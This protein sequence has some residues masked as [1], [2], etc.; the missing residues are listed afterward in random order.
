MVIARRGSCGPGFVRD[1]RESV[2]VSGSGRGLLAR[3]APWLRGRASAAGSGG[4]LPGLSDLELP[5]RLLLAGVGWVGAA[6][7]QA[8]HP[9]Q[10][11]FILKRAARFGRGSCGCVPCCCSPQLLW[12]L[13]N[14]QPQK[15]GWTPSPFSVVRVGQA[16]SDLCRKTYSCKAS[17]PPVVQTI[18]TFVFGSWGGQLSTASWA[19]SVNSRWFCPWL[20][21]LQ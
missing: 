13:R 4:P 16:S 15:C 6:R 12:A 8:V 9:G 11:V 21:F 7:Q 19:Q 5:G 10:A 20:P 14:L 17:V 18:R 1:A 2:G 3:G